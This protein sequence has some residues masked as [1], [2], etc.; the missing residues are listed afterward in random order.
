MIQPAFPVTP[1]TG[2]SAG[3]QSV[4]QPPL[5]RSPQRGGQSLAQAAG[6]GDPG[7]RF[8][9]LA[10]AKAGLRVGCQRRLGPTL[11]EALVPG[12]PVNLLNGAWVLCSLTLAVSLC[13]PLCWLC[14]A[15][16]CHALWD[17]T[18]ERGPG[19]GSP[20]HRPRAEPHPHWPVQEQSAPYHSPNTPI[21]H[22]PETTALKY[23]CQSP[24][25]Q[26]PKP[27]F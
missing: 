26:H 21:Q 10:E 1:I 8:Q 9:E 25:P 17:A 2:M 27:P 24:P 6:V 7:P 14:V 19:L 4:H 11:R 13:W 20:K 23:M 18:A 15:H 3:S 16:Q 22:R 5:L 12:A